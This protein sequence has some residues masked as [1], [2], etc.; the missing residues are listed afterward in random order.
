MTQPET[1]DKQA[2]VVASAPIFPEI[3]KETP[4]A[5]SRLGRETKLPKL[6]NAVL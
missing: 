6:R 1:F 4:H 3:A 5:E 2:W